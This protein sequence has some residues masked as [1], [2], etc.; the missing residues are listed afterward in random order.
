MARPVLSNVQTKNLSFYPSLGLLF[1]ALHTKKKENVI[2]GYF[3]Q[4]VIIPKRVLFPRFTGTKSGS[5][6]P[7]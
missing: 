4:A 5:G 1:V 2:S 3:S 6:R 7:Q